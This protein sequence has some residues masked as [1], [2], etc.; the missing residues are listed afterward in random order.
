[1]SESQYPRAQSQSHVTAYYSEQ[2][3]AEY[4]RLELRVIQYLADAGIISGVQMVGE[5]QPC[6]DDAALVLLRRVRR[7]YHDLD[8]NLEGIEIIL[9]LSTRI[10]ALQRE[11]ARYQAMAERGIGERQTGNDTLDW[12]EAEE[13]QL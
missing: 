9:R 5:M 6:Y 13:Q 8:V 2:Q 7:L 4:S 11:L 12:P 10:D 1:M 3:T